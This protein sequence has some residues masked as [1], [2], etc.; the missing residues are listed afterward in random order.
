[1]AT[2]VK[3]L[4]FYKKSEDIFEKYKDEKLICKIY[5]KY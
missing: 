5:Q 3:K 2:K 1:M 4:D